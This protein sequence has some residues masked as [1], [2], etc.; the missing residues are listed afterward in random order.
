MLPL[1]TRYLSPLEY[2]RL[3]HD[4]IIAA[5]LQLVMLFGLEAVIMRWHGTVRQQ[6]PDDLAK[7]WGGAL[8][9]MVPGTIL[10]TGGWLTYCATISPRSEGVY[11]WTVPLLAIGGACQ[12]ISLTRLQAEFRALLFSTVAF[13][14]FAGVSTIL[15]I[16]VHSGFRDAN[17]LVAAQAL[18]QFGI[19][20]ASLMFLAN[21]IRPRFFLPSLRT[22]WSYAW[23]LLP[24]SSAGFLLAQFDRIALAN[25]GGDRSLGIYNVSLQ[26]G[27]ILSL[28]TQGFNQAFAPWFFRSNLE[29][30]KTLAKLRFLTIHV[31]WA[32][33][34]LATLLP[35]ALDF[36]Q[37]ILIGPLYGEALRRTP[38]IALGYAFQVQY[39][40]F[41]A[42]L[43]R[44]RP[45]LVTT[46]SFGA[47]VFACIINP[48]LILHFSI[49]GAAIA[50]L[51]NFAAIA[52][53]SLILGH[54]IEGIKQP[55]VINGSIL[56]SHF[57][58]AILSQM[59]VA[60]MFGG[61]LA[62]LTL[63]ATLSIAAFLMSIHKSKHIFRDGEK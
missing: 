8:F 61:H 11:G 50:F 4:L 1:Y 54:G 47:L 36:V 35:I 49:T 16:L 13:V 22:S 42:P 21:R 44:S 45:L 7:F 57:S 20:G 48:L 10:A 17:S 2:G 14:Q 38:L 41:S 27:S 28:V 18:C 6:G 34:I 15:V 63:G 40:L 29:D 5:F 51:G 33:A 25:L 59:P 32:C 60:S 23:R 37:G 3:T 52:F 26:L 56:V 24:H 43:F 58:I 31:P 62:I 39:M 53:F 9:L 12:Q 46:C 30:P 19:G 55:W